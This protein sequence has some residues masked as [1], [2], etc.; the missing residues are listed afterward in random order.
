MVVPGPEAAEGRGEGGG[1][2]AS[3]GA[4]VE[5][6]SV[7]WD[8]SLVIDTGG[9]DPV[10]VANCGNYTYNVC[11]MYCAAIPHEDGFRSLDGK[12]SSEAVPILAAA[13]AYMESHA[14]EMRKFNPKNGWGSYE[15]ALEYLRTIRDDCQRHP[16]ATVQIS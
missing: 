11:Q 4:G 8:T 3:R 1:D 15:G 9:E 16:K 14:E 5:G 10:E 12:L 13:I 6:S 2:A 7:S